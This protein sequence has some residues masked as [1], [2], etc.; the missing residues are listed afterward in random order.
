MVATRSIFTPNNSGESSRDV[1]SKNPLGKNFSTGS[2]SANPAIEQHKSLKRQ[3]PTRK[4]EL[5][6]VTIFIE[7]LQ[8][9]GFRREQ[10]HYAFSFLA[11]AGFSTA[12][13]AA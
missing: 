3:E 7:T 5:A 13:V 9:L 6:L 2:S 11:L 12:G 8:R 4:S 10:I 1:S